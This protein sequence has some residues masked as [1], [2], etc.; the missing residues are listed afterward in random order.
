MQHSL[1]EH[2]QWTSPAPLPSRDSGEQFGHA[3]LGLRRGA[4]G[5]VVLSC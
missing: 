3:L 4:N 5:D 2:M 1:F